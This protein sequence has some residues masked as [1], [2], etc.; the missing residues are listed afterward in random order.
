[1]ASR[2]T[3]SHAALYGAI[4]SNAPLK[5]AVN[6]FFNGLTNAGQ[7]RPEF[8]SIGD[9][10]SLE[11][12]PVQCSNREI[13]TRSHELNQTFA[14]IC[15]VPDRA[16]QKLEEIFELFCEAVWQDFDSTGSLNRIIED[17]QTFVMS[18]DRI[19]NDQGISVIQGIWTVRVLVAKW[20][21]RGA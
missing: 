15:Y 21:P 14:V 2:L 9:M 8:P 7:V 4:T 1:M 12:R 13:A 18:I 10:P 6:Q 20:N 19:T 5:A 16:V 11:L 3:L 17:P